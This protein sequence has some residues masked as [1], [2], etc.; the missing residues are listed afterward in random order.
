M[1]KYLLVVGG[2]SLLT[3]YSPEGSDNRVSVPYIMYDVNLSISFDIVVQDFD[4]CLGLVKITL[5][6][7]G[8]L[9]LYSSN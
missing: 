7:N 5:Q 1:L 4:F 8:Q 6:F 3:P 9:Y 2:L